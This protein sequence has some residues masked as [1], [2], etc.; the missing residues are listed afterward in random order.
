MDSLNKTFDTERSYSRHLLE[1]PWLL[2]SFTVI[3]LYCF[4]L[5]IDLF[6]YCL[7]P[8]VMVNKVE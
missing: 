5:M 7:L 6:T 1:L 3:L 4:D 2:C 8:L